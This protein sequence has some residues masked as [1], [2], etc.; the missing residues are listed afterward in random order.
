[1]EERTQK[2]I[3]NRP[4]TQQ[5]KQV[6]P[7]TAWYASWQAIMLLVTESAA[8]PASAAASCPSVRPVLLRGSQWQLLSLVKGD[9]NSHLFGL[10]IP[11]QLRAWLNNW[12][13]LFWNESPSRWPLNSSWSQPPTS[14]RKRDISNS[15]IPILWTSWEKPWVFLIPEKPVW[16]GSKSLQIPSL[17]EAD[18]TPSFVAS[19][20]PNTCFQPSS[21]QRNAR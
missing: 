12:M 9:W 14:F 7:K 1:M 18:P 11:S 20:N 21:H 5:K 10:G 17:R 13:L 19:S 8:T 6:C 3:F 2:K 15:C 4:S 16:T